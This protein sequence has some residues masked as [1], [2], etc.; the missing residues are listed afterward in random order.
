MGRPLRFGSLPAYGL[1]CPPDLLDVVGG[2][3]GVE[4][5]DRLKDLAARLT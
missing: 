1:C 4:L 3:Q 2:V 5:M